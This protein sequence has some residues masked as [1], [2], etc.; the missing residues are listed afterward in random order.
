MS[1]KEQSVL[2]YKNAFCDDDYSEAEKF[3]NLFFDKVLTLI[4]GNK[5]VSQLFL[6]DAVYNRKEKL[7]YIYAA[8]TDEAYQ[9][10]GYMS[11]LLKEA[12]EFAKKNEYSGIY[13]YPATD[14]L[15]NY[16]KKQSFF[17]CF[18]TDFD[19]PAKVVP[20][21]KFLSFCNDVLYK[22]YLKEKTT[23]P[24]MAILFN[25]N[26]DTHAYITELGN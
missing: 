8:A 12:I 1:L 23:A 19:C 2:L 10:K 16:Y 26:I 4:R 15:R 6:I 18:K 13:L 20:E 9:N 5:L 7:K 11:T 14:K 21:E 17:D 22:D 25:E 24:A 3:V